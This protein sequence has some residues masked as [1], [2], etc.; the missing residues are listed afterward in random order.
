MYTAKVKHSIPSPLAKLADDAMPNMTN[1]ARGGAKM[2]H[3][4]EIYNP[5]LRHHE[6]YCQH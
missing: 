5:L 2:F 6:L 3:L 4:A 1:T